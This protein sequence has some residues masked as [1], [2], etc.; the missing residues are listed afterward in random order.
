MA[1][2]FDDPTGT[3]V[4]VMNAEGQYALWPTFKDV[5]PGWSSAGPTGSRQACLDYIEAHWTDMRPNS[6]KRAMG[7]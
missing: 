6:L 7:G 2:P 5:P 3:F 1:N 4:V